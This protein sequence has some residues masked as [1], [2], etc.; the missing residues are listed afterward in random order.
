MTHDLDPQAHREAPALADDP[1]D[2]K[3]DHGRVGYGRIGSFSP[4]A[5]CLVVSMVV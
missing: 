1:E 2:A 4:L 3:I 5:L